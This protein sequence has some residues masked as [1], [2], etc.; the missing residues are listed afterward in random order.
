[1]FSQSLYLAVY[2]TIQDLQRESGVDCFM[3]DS[4]QVNYLPPLFTTHRPLC[5]PN[6]Y[7]KQYVQL[8]S[9]TDTERLSLRRVGWHSQNVPLPLVLD[10]RDSCWGWGNGLKT[11]IPSVLT[12]GLM[13]YPYL[14]PGTVGGGQK[15]D[16]ELFVRWLQV[17]VLM[18]SVMM[19]VPAWSYG[20]EVERIVAD[21]LALRRK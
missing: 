3:F 10:E 11:L 14:L 16:A 21:L 8:A 9:D 19:S 1:M 12:L 13:G 2:A 17:T 15:A 7:S 20:E 18:P 5:S 4:G 6:D